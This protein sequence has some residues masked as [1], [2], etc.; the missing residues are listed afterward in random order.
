MSNDFQPETEE[1]STVAARPQNQIVIGILQLILVT[2]VVLLAVWINL[3]ISKG[4]SGPRK[5][6][7]GPSQL[8]V[9]VIQPTPTAAQIRISETGTLEVRNTVSLIPQISGRVIAVS[10][11]LAAGGTFSSGEVLFRI[12]PAD[13]RAAVDQAQ[14]SVYSASSNLDLVLAEAEIARREWEMVHPG[15]PI[16]PLVA[17]LPQIRQAKSALTSSEAALRSARLNLSRVDYSVPFRGRVLTSTLEVGQTLTSGQSYGEIYA[18]DSLEI[19]ISLSIETLNAIQPAIGRAAQIELSNG[20]MADRLSATVVRVDAMLDAR[21]RLARLILTFDDPQTLPPGTF[22]K[23]VIDGPK[24]DSAYTI[25][26]KALSRNATIW[27]V[28]EGRLEPRAPVIIATERDKII[29]S[30]FDI[31]EGVVVTPLNN[32]EAGAKVQLSDVRN[33]SRKD[34]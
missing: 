30:P 4:S 13:V 34:L 11:N 22:V 8:V 14:A 27:I 28:K 21:T 5:R 17:R 12:D 19:S 3:A 29:T 9:D 7:S 20:V 1:G 15:E 33:Q 24:V 16:S 18:Q 6:V 10:S 23:A 26:A 32:P 2:S 31:G 25:P